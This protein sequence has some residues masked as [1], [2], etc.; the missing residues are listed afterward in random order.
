MVYFKCPVIGIGFK[1]PYLQDSCP[2]RAVWG[3]EGCGH[4][5][6]ASCKHSLLPLVHSWHHS[7]H[8]S[9]FVSKKII[10]R[11]YLIKKKKNPTHTDA[12]KRSTLMSIHLNTLLLSVGVVGLPCSP[13]G[14]RHRG[15]V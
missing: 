11:V 14:V 6:D 15:T 12:Q 10:M 2:P 5:Q 1:P 4:L 7:I 8:L 13:V 9:K 3:E